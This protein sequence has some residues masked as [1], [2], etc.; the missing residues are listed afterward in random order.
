MTYK[1]LYET[2][3]RM[4]DSGKITLGEYE[5]MIEPLNEKVRQTAVWLDVEERVQ[6]RI[7]LLQKCP[8]CKKRKDKGVYWNFCPNCGTKM[9]TQ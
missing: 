6:S 9:L 2:A 5:K 1:E 4:V 7:K 3:Q 8:V